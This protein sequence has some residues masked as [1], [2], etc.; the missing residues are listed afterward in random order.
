M[1]KNTHMHC[2]WKN[3][4]PWARGLL[5][6]AEAI[7]CLR[8]RYT[9]PL[10]NVLLIMVIYRDLWREC[11]FTKFRRTNFENF[12]ASLWNLVS[13]TSLIRRPFVSRRGLGSNSFSR[14]TDERN[15][16]CIFVKVL[17]VFRISYLMHLHIIFSFFIVFC[18][19]NTL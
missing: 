5:A 2:Y 10:K 12:S 8:Q 15:T 19:P 13:G 18:K 4:K 1:Y 9:P 7:I 3:K 14:S 17:V 16:L 6:G 11:A